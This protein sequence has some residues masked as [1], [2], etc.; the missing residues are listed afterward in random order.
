M[1]S[2]YELHLGEIAGLVDAMAEDVAIQ[3]ELLDNIARE[4]LLMSRECPNEQWS[5]S[6]AKIVDMTSFKE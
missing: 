2:K 1:T 6:F 4:A 5:K 3:D